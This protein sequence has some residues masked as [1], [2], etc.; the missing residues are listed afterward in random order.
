MKYIEKEPFIAKTFISELEEYKQKNKNSNPPYVSGDFRDKFY[1][2]VYFGLLIRQE[3][4]CAY[5]ES[6]ILLGYAGIEK[7]FD[8]KTSLYCGIHENTKG[9]DGS[10]DHFDWNMKTDF[11]W[12]L[13]NLFLIREFI[14]TDKGRNNVP[15]CLNPSNPDYLPEKYMFYSFDQHRFYVNENL[16]EPLK[17]QIQK[18][19]DE[20]LGINSYTIV[21][22]RTHY[23][24][25][26]RVDIEEGQTIEFIKK[27][28]HHKF[29]TAFEMSEFN[30]TNGSVT[31]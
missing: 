30:L 13:L 11:G 20:V 6:P 28:K 29:F 22:E 24:N 14:N 19:L 5:S 4:L 10:I 9:L 3:G 1:Y 16:Q 15:S 18:A 12:E 8:P 21:S 31:V 27:K 17:T 26:F 23:L 2:S 7:E 25:S